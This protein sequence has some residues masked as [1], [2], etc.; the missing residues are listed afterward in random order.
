MYKLVTKEGAIAIP[1]ERLGEDMDKVIEEMTRSSFEGEVFPD[2]SVIIL[3]TN[4]RKVGDGT[5]PHG[6]G[7]VFQMIRYDGLVFKPDTQEVVQ[8]TVCEVLK[9]GAFVRFGPLDGLIH[10]SQI[11]DDKVDADLANARLIGKT[12]KRDLR[13][14]DKIR[15]RI[16]AISANERNPRESKIGLTMRQAGLG[17]FE[18]I[19]EERGGGKKEKEKKGKEKKGKEKKA[20]PAEKK[21]VAKK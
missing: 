18:W 2:H 7:R 11:M 20:P 9:F 5:I 15:A 14:G 21:D 17:K 10:I 12:N 13:S 3:T 4:I 19:E 16:V 1:P 8:G 6:E